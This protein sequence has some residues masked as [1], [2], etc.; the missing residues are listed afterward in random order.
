MSN[1][2]D[3]AAAGMVEINKRDERIAELERELGLARDLADQ[4]RL[5]AV[6]PRKITM[7]EVLEAFREN[8]AQY[9]ILRERLY[10]TE[11]E[12]DAEKAAREKAEADKH[13]ARRYLA[14]VTDFANA[15]AREDGVQE[16][17][18]ELDLHGVIDRIWSKMSARRVAAEAELAEERGR[19]LAVVENRWLVIDGCSGWG[20]YKE[21]GRASIITEAETMEAAIDEARKERT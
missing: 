17:H 16:A 9:G 14:S 5:Q 10:E 3:V 19:L 11:Q 4:A 13:E 21:R 7:D 12:R 6:Q 18:D 2:L 1:I 15:W 8:T 20:V